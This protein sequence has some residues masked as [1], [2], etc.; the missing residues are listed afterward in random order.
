MPSAQLWLNPDEA[1]KRGLKRNDLVWIESR[2]GKI[3]VRV[4]TGGRN[5]VPSGYAFVP[6]FDEAVF[7]N[8][9]TLDTTCPIS[10]ETDYK[11]CAVKVYKA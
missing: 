8:R 6:W 1:K 5:H 4:E 10:K 3:K 2:R 9:L 11:K 7:I